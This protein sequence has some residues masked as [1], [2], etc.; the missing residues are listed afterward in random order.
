MYA[1]AKQIETEHRGRLA[2]IQSELQTL[3]VKQKQLAEVV[4]RILSLA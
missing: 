1:A 4:H 3:H 2:K